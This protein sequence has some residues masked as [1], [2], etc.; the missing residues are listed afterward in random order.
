MSKG[1][2]S[3]SGKM[4]DQEEVR[5]LRDTGAMQSFILAGKV[6]L[7]DI[8]FCGSSVIVQGIEMG[9]VKFPLQRMHLQSELCTGFVRVAVCPS[10]PVKGVDFILGNDLAGGKVMPV[11]EVVDEPNVFCELDVLSETYPDVFPACAVTRAQLRRVGDVVD[12]SNSFMFPLLSGDASLD[13]NLEKKNS[14][15]TENKGV[16]VSDAELLKLP[17]S[18]ENCCCTERG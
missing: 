13:M 1:L 2:I 15:K 11:I 16:V 7:S 18:R 8:T 9:C 5:I 10:L 14:S 17:V 3:L 4:E 6:Q 12:L